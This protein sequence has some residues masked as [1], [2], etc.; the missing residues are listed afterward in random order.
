MVVNISNFCGDSNTGLRS[1]LPDHD[2]TY[3]LIR[4]PSHAASFLSPASC[5]SVCVHIIF[6]G[7]SGCIIERLLEVV[8]TRSNLFILWQSRVVL[9]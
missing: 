8:S 5:H 9:N 1:R 2:L 4:L 7:Q 6:I 3:L